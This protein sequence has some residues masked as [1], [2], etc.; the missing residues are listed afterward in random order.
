MQQGDLLV[1][2]G[3]DGTYPPGLPVARI[4]QIER[5][6]DTA[7]L[8]CVLHEPS[9]RGALAPPAAGDPLRS[10]SCR[11]ANPSTAR[12]TPRKPGSSGPT[13]RA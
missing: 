5:K 1:T 6:A 2:S 12:A 3:L 9:G 11:R 4:V 7:L 8:A 10:I 13:G